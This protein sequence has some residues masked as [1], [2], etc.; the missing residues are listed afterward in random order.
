ML[1]TLIIP[2]HLSRSPKHLAPL[3]SIHQLNPTAKK[4]NNALLST[5]RFGHPQLRI[6]FQADAESART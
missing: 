6:Y 4:L 1:L 2:K 3:P 5:Q